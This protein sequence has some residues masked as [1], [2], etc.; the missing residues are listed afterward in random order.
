MSVAMTLPDYDEGFSGAVRFI[1]S[2]RGIDR[3]ILMFILVVFIVY[4]ISLGFVALSG[5]FFVRTIVSPLQKIN[6]VAR[7]FADGNFNVRVETD[8]EDE[9]EITEL[10]DSI[11]AMIAE[12]AATDQLKNDF[13]STVSHEL[14][15]PLTAIKG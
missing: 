14:R 11:N 8:V 1:T 12:V 7:D 4:L 2:M 3:Q 10:S 13:I 6:D 5:M 9:D 15:T